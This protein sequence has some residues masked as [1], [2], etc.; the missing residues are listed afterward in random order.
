MHADRR[1]SGQPPTGSRTGSTYSFSTRIINTP[2]VHR[3]TTGAHGGLHRI[4][5]GAGRTMPR[6]CSNCGS[7]RPCRAQVTLAEDD[8]TL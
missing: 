7:G 1:A 6:G 3:R 8:G 5:G 4:A 2:Q